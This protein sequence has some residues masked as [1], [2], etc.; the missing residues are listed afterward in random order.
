MKRFPNRVALAMLVAIIV[1]AWAQASPH[2]CRQ[3]LLL[4]IAS[5]DS[6]F[7]AVTGRAT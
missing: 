1:P 5:I 6:L 4:R 3:Q 7:A 2:G